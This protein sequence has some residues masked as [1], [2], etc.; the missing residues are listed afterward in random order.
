M[1][2][3]VLSGTD[4]IAEIAAWMYA[5][6]L[7]RK[8]NAVLGLA[9]GSSP[10]KTYDRLIEMCRSGNISFRDAKA[11]LL[12][13]YWGL[14]PEH[15]ETYRNFIR[16]VL[17]SH[18]DF[19]PGAVHGPDGAAR[20]PRVAAEAYEQEILSSGGIDLQI[21]GIGADGHI[22]FN[23]PGG[24]LYSPC[25]AQVLLQ[26]TRVDNARFFG[27]DVDAVPTAAITQGL[28]TIMRARKIVLIAQ[29]KNK[30]DAV[31]RMVERGVSAMCPASIL[32]FHND[33]TV[34]LDSEAAS[35]LKL[36]DHYAAEWELERQ[37]PSALSH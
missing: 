23:E 1:K 16:R 26:K 19:A 29:G 33:V 28:A 35:G 12:D 13:E 7:H 9:T 6:V 21:L 25:H 11:Y 2:I 10:L 31:K 15:P 24:S 34:L 20:D 30:A 5:S 17:T 4:E 3:A 36:R 8:P 14:D 27:D 22:A 37:L 18:V 32:Q